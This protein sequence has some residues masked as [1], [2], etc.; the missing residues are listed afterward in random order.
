M[1]L[2]AP[3][4]EDEYALVWELSNLAWRRLRLFRAAA[5][6]ERR[7]LRLAI[8]RYAQPGRI[9]AAETL[10]RMYLLLAT[11][12]NF[13]RVLKD[14]ARVRDE[15]Q[16]LTLMLVEGRQ[17][18]EGSKQKAEGSMQKAEGNWPEPEVE[19]EKLE[20]G[21]AEPVVRRTDVDDERDDSVL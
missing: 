20:A 16:Q 6:R 17:E 12:D 21:G 9:G 4:T 13:D 7:D 5:E 18:T 3:R 2:F 8:E 15:I 14:A 1:Q 10:D 19:I 11:L